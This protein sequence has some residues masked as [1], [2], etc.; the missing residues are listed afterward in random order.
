ME[1]MIIKYLYIDCELLVGLVDYVIDDVGIGLVYIVFGYGDDDYNFGKK[2]NLLI[3]VL[4]N[5]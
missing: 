3:F 1:G 5:D 4:M 2:Y